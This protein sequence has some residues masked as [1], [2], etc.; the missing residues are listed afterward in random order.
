MLFSLNSD[1]LIRPFLHRSTDE[2]ILSI[3]STA[4][5]FN[6]IIILSFSSLERVVKE[7]FTFSY[8]VRTR[9]NLLSN[10]STKLF[11]INHFYDIKTNIDFV[12]LRIILMKLTTE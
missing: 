3:I 7:S 10:L 4:T 9:F 5:G 12:I 8:V 2:V 11:S 6:F 1:S